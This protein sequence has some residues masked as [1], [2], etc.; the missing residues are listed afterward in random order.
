MG[1]F[2]NFKISKLLFYDKT[3]HIEQVKHNWTGALA[4]DATAFFSGNTVFLMRSGVVNFTEIIKIT[5][6]LIKTTFKNSMKIKEIINL[7]IKFVNF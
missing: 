6:N 2:Q 5:M 7:C 3:E 1:K 4:V